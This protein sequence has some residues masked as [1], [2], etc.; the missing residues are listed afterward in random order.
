MP[1][2]RTGN[3]PNQYVPPGPLVSRRAL[4]TSGIGLRAIGDAGVDFS[5]PQRDCDPIVLLWQML[6]Q[7]RLRTLALVHEA[8]CAGAAGDLSR[9]DALEY[10]A[11]AIDDTV[12]GLDERIAGFPPASP[13]AAV[14]QAGLLLERLQMM[15][16]QDEPETALARHLANY[17]ANVRAR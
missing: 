17:L 13:Q 4:M 14:I 6:M 16:G 10:F 5:L 11:G 9:Q 15:H 2:R 1:M 12:L 3:D 8:L 7:Q